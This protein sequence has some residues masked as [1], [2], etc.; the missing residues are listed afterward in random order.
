MVS[1]VYIKT[2]TVKMITTILLMKCLTMFFFVE[3]F[4]NISVYNLFIIIHLLYGNYI[5]GQEEFSI[6]YYYKCNISNIE[7]GWYL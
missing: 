1:Y 6:M 3:F 7:F 2:S 5:F 4:R